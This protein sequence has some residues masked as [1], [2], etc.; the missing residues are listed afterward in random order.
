MVLDGYVTEDSGTG[1]VHQAAYFGQVSMYG[2]CD[3]VQ[4]KGHL[5]G[6]VYSEMMSKT[7]CKI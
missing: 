4:H 2:V 3:P 1:V 7:V 6:Q 5:V